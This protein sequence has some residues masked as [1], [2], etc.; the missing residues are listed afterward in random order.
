M[1]R[2]HLN[3]LDRVAAVALVVLDPH[4]GELN[5]AV[6]IREVV[7][8]SPLPDL[9]GL[10]IRTTRRVR[11]VVI[12]PLEEPLI[13]ALQFAVQDNAAQT[14]ATGQQA[15]GCFRIRTIEASVMREL[16]RLH[17]AR[18]ERLLACW[19]VANIARRGCGGIAV[20]FR[21]VA[22]PA[23]HLRRPR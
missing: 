18:M 7:L 3:V 4:I 9:L 12:R 17:D 11:A 5:V 8:A 20:S 1:R 16:S 15:I 6:A 13:L 19:T 23:G 14:S 2:R 10:P 21:V 22:R